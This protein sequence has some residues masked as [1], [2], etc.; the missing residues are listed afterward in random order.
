MNLNPSITD[1]FSSASF[2]GHHAAKNKSTDPSTVTWSSRGKGIYAYIL[3][4]L[5]F[6]IVLK[7]TSVGFSV[8]FTEI[9]LGRY[10]TGSFVRIYDM[11]PMA[12]VVSCIAIGFKFHIMVYLF[13]YAITLFERRLIWERCEKPWAKKNCY[14]LTGN[15]TYYKM[16]VQEFNASY[17]NELYWESSG[18]QYWKYVVLD[19]F[20][21]IL[22]NLFT[23]L[24][25]CIAVFVL[26][27]KGIRSL[28]KAFT[29]LL[30]IP[31][32]LSVLLGMIAFTRP[33]F[34]SGMESLWVFH[35]EKLL[36]YD[37]W[38]S[39]FE[40]TFLV[41]NN[42]LFVLSFISSHSNFYDDVM[43]DVLAVIFSHVFFGSFLIAPIFSVL[44]VYGNVP[45]KN[46]HVGSQT[47]LCLAVVEAFVEL[48]ENR[49]NIYYVSG[50]MAV[51]EL[52]MSEALI[53]PFQFSV[54]TNVLFFLLVIQ[55]VYGYKRYNDNFHF[56]M[57][58][59]PP[60]IFHC[61]EISSTDLLQAFK[62]NASWGPKVPLLSKSRV[63]FNSKDITKEFMYRKE[64]YKKPFMK[65][66]DFSDQ[67]YWVL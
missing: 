20:N 59:Q 63:V 64:L 58:Y 10:V 49:I 44:K 60:F 33:G 39:A 55:L 2:A 26:N 31:M 22:F 50:G 15:A 66:K 18:M 40:N 1:V 52:T 4:T 47:V 6:T 51:L 35:W 30:W 29:L 25:F 42:G 8:S 38:L 17:C 3:S 45:I 61:L 46:F 48:T 53:Y 9:L 65:T 19:D 27:Y 57:G 13:K 62:Y 23:L 56:M 16:C 34:L 28:E 14:S 37:L 11:C 7:Y 41:N 36:N 43:Y 5:S 54:A 24:G 21:F 32:F 67:L 12:K